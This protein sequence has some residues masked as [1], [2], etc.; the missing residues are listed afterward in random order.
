MPR[1]SEEI[2]RTRVSVTSLSNKAG[3]PKSVERFK[4]SVKRKIGIFQ[5]ILDTSM[6]RD[7]IF[8]LFTFSNFCT[9]IGFYVPYVYV[10]VCMRIAILRYRLNIETKNE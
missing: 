5:Q 8:I 10:L 4:D 1:H 6:L 3:Q 2:V 7:P 9:S